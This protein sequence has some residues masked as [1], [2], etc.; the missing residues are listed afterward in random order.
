MLSYFEPINLLT[1][2]GMSIQPIISISLFHSIKLHNF[3]RSVTYVQS[4]IVIGP[5]L[6]DLPCLTDL[7]Q[8]FCL[9]TLEAESVAEYILSSSLEID[10]LNER[11]S[12][13]LERLPERFFSRDFLSQIYSGL[14]ERCKIVFWEFINTFE[15]SVLFS[16]VLFGDSMLSFRFALFFFLF[17]SSHRLLWSTRSSVSEAALNRAWASYNKMGKVLWIIILGKDLVG[18][19]WGVLSIYWADKIT[20]SYFLRGIASWIDSADLV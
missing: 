6:L 11:V 9:S 10:L 7:S 16:V 15:R 5:H 3:I 12:G 2:S 20:L 18:E 1:E 19:V 14:G 8:A 13:R 17:C 4:K